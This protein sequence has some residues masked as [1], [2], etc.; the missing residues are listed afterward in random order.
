MRTLK[1]ICTVVCLS[2]L[3]FSFS[4]KHN[5]SQ[6][7][8][9]APASADTLVSPY[10]IEPLTLPQ[11]QEVY[12]I[13]CSSCHG[14]SG[15]GDGITSTNLKVKPLDFQ[16]GKVGSQTNG[17]IFWKIREG[18]GEMPSFKTVLSEEQ[19]W[20]MVEYIRDITKPYEEQ[21]NPLKVKH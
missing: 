2:T 15:K 16:D 19:K 8:W 5:I 12:T 3:V 11:G 13:Y 18:R 7:P 4:F 6:E 1:I 20:Q 17:A 10:L 14:H 9:K 21:L